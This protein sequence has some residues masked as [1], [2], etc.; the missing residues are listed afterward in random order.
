MLTDNQII[1][2]E[3]RDD[4]NDGRELFYVLAER[5]ETQW[6][7]FERSAWELRW[8]PLP[9]TDRLVKKALIEG[10]ESPTCMSKSLRMKQVA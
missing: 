6:R 4:D 3:I 2:S 9:S 7:F 10:A 5:H 8:Y 1:W